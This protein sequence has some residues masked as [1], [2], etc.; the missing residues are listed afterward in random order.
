MVNV[1]RVNFNIATSATRYWK[2]GTGISGWV[3]V[4]LEDFT[5]AHDMFLDESYSRMFFEKEGIKFIANWL[6]EEGYKVDYWESD[7]TK[8]NYNSTAGPQVV[9]YGLKF[10][11]T[12]DKFIELKLRA[13]K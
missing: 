7:L 11:N 8:P 3:D 2:G 1:T 12:C 13:N 4:M 9:A 10:E 6:K 5:T